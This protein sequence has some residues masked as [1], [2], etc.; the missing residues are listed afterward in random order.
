MASASARITTSPARAGTA[1]ASAVAAMVRSPRDQRWPE[2]ARHNPRCAAIHGAHGDERQHDQAQRGEGEQRDVRGSW[3]ASGYHAS[4]ACCRRRLPLRQETP[5]GR[6][7]RAHQARRCE[8]EALAR[9]LGLQQAQGLPVVDVVPAGH[10]DDRHTDL[11]G[12]LDGEAINLRR[13][14]GNVRRTR[15]RAA[16]TGR[17]ACS[18]RRAPGSAPRHPRR[19]GARRR[20]RAGSTA[21]RSGCRH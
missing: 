16:A 11:G 13:A 8:G 1:G 20:R 21:A 5:R 14:P 6:R 7:R 12:A 19:R 4:P 18:R 9:E 17:S 2:R 15:A 10:V 3:R